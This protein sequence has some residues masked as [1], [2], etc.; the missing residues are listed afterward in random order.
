MRQMQIL[1]LNLHFV[2][3]SAPRWAHDGGFSGYI[4]PPSGGWES[5]EESRLG[6][7]RDE[8]GEEEQW[9]QVRLSAQETEGYRD[10][11]DNRASRFVMNCHDWTAGMIRHIQDLVYTV[12]STQPCNNVIMS[13]WRCVLVQKWTLKMYLYQRLFT[14][15]KQ[16]P[17][18][19][20]K[21]SLYPN[22]KKKM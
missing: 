13:V 6:E 19:L 1:N 4:L 17:R 7:Q 8:W 10:M 5:R 21:T 22:G 12:Y 11:R 20:S 18:W 15:L 16:K 14:E 2:I 3:E 9:S